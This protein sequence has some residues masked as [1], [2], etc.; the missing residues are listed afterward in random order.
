ML[1]TMFR[2]SPPPDEGYFYRPK[3]GAGHGDVTPGDESDADDQATLRRVPSAEPR[4]LLTHDD[5]AE[6]AS[7]TSPLI[8]VRSREDQRRGYGMRQGDEH[9]VDL[10]GQKHPGRGT[11]F[12]RM[13][14][15]L[16]D[17]GNRIASVLTIVGNPKRWDRRVLWQNAVVAPVACLPAVVVGLLLNILDALSYGK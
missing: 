2:R 16:R 10:E 15:S 12:G 6:D 14:G 17:T 5:A 3:E 13:S 11:W 4:P 1:T 8:A 7:E 9:D